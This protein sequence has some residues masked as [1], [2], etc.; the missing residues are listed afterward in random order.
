MLSLQKNY[1]NNKCYVEK[2]S[3]N[4]VDPH[5]LKILY[6]RICLLAKI[7]FS[8][9]NKY[10]GSSGDHHGHEQGSEKSESPDLYVPHT[11]PFCLA[12]IL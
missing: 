3:G 6:L 7:Y 12:L 4:T 2:K 11:L 1:N 5:Y 9:Q 10:L 8:F